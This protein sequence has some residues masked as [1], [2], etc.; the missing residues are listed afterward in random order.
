MYRENEGSFSKFIHR[1]TVQATICSCYEADSLLHSPLLL[2]E[3]I[4]PPECP[5]IIKDNISQKHSAKTQE[6]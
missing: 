1:L 4:F 2:S 6:S 5:I 3:Q